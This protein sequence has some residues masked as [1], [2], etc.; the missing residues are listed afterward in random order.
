M[1]SI[2]STRFVPS[3][4]TSK[5]YRP[6]CRPFFS[7][8]A[9]CFRGFLLEADCRLDC[10]CVRGFVAVALTGAG[11]SLELF[12]TASRT[13]RMSE[14]LLLREDS[15]TSFEALGLSEASGLSLSCEGFFA[16][17]LGFLTVAC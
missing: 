11:L 13:E 10:V 7:P 8:V 14:N 4:V 6:D 9:G 12:E 2:T 16:G 5:K 15:K 17:G 1:W 3:T